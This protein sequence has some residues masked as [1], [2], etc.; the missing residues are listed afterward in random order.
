MLCLCGLN[1]D[2]SSVCLHFLH[3][4]SV[5]GS[6]V[7]CGLVFALYCWFLSLVHS[8][9]YAN[10]PSTAVWQLLNSSRS[11]D[12]WHRLHV[13]LGVSTGASGWV[14]SRQALAYPSPLV[15]WALKS[16][17]DFTFLQVLHFLV[18][19]FSSSALFFLLCSSLMPVSYTHLTL[20]TKA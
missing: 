3:I 8:R 2:I 12:S 16:A 11:F 19:P 14:H 4:C 15:G 13:L 7:R 6:V 9:Q 1:N 18:A 5:T 20:P 17:T 10:R